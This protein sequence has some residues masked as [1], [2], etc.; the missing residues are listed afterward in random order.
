MLC[1]TAMNQNSDT[2]KMEASDEWQMD[3]ANCD[4]KFEV[5]F[6]AGQ[7]FSDSSDGMLITIICCTCISKN[8]IQIFFLSVKNFSRLLLYHTHILLL[9]EIRPIEIITFWQC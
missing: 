5:D 2:I 4:V 1:F 6:D 9:Q 7:I 8:V 3:F